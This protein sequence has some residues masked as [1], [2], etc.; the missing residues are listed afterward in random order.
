M[1]A[2]TRRR[3]WPEVRK[4]ELSRFPEVYAAYDAFKRAVKAG[5]TPSPD[6][7]FILVESPDR[8]PTFSSED[9]E[10]EYWG[11]HTLGDAWFESVEPL[12]PDEL[13]PSGRRPR[14]QREGSGSRPE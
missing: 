4:E 13:P 11:T 3:R 9:E 5:K 1:A 7:P 12:D 14:A 10:H 2:G 8:L 6:R